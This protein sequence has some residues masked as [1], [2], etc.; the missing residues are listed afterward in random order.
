MQKR[1]ICF[2]CSIESLDSGMPICTLRLVKHF[3]ALPEWDVHV[4]LP[5]SGQFS[6]SL[7][8]TDARV[9]IIPFAKLRSPRR[10]PLSEF[11]RCIAGLPLAALRIMLYLRRNAVVLVHFSDFIDSLFYPAASM[12][13]AKVVAHLRQN[14]ENRG[15]R[16]FY[17]A[18]SALWV[19]KVVCISRSVQR[20]SGLRH[21]IIS[22]DPG[23]DPAAFDLQ[24]LPDKTSPV[25]GVVTV[26]S[27]AK[28]V[29]AK[30]H[31]ELVD[32][33]AR[34]VAALPAKVHFRIIG[35]KVPLREGYYFGV[36]DKIASL[37][38]DAVFSIIDQVDPG[39]IPALLRAADI[40][41]HLPRYQEGL[42]GVVLE[43]MA[44]EVPVVAYDSGGV[45]ECFE[46]NVAGFLVPQF[47]DA[48][49]ADRI[50]RLAQD[51][52]LRA[53]MG[54]N[55]RVEVL[56]RFPVDRHFNEIANLYTELL[57]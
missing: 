30:G 40:F 52:A 21:T 22:Y 3:A 18:W 34:V 32:V 48:A 25:D 42:G 36:M 43:A 10:V 27:I 51:P 19:N 44:M 55:G 13:G 26:L 15:Q 12:A 38:L 54:R 56:R 11:I 35:G 46:N 53:T 8:E 41:I 33:A 37:G 7:Q 1:A 16:F 31:A 57:Q 14:I 6:R 29:E 5:A 20:F 2:V 9:A 45:G 50:V 28:F 4:I 49:A 17:R 24:R 23:P 47:D 39:E